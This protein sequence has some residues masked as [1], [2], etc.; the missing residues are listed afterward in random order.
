MLDR[1]DR[2]AHRRGF[3]LASEK[4][5]FD[6]SPVSQYMRTIYFDDSY[7]YDLA[8]LEHDIIE[9]CA[10][11]AIKRENLDHVDSNIRAGI[12]FAKHLDMCAPPAFLHGMKL[13][14]AGIDPFVVEN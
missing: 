10:H 7:G 5:S 3:H 13:W 8:G 12:A 2:P 11:C 14:L 6:G 4:Q 9:G 1:M